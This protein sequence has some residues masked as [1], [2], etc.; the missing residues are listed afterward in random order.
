MPIPVQKASTLA[1]TD[2]NHVFTNRELYRQKF[3]LFQTD[4]QNKFKNLQKP[5]A[6]FYYWLKVDD[7]LKFVQD[8]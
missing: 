1:W 4:L 6:S 5:Q 2:E 7:D 3:E 8:C